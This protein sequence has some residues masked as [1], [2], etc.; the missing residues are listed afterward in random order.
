M[1]GGGLVLAGQD[2]DGHEI[3]PAQGTV[4]RLDGRRGSVLEP[5][6]YPL[7]AICME[8]GG[9]VREDAYMFAKWYHVE[10]QGAAT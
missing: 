5:H 7:L 10:V 1:T 3:V 4:R 2:R 6:D 8:C 9:R